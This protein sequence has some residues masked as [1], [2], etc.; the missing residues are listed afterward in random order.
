MLQQPLFLGQG[1]GAGF[2]VMPPIVACGLF[3]VDALANGKCSLCNAD[4]DKWL[5]CSL[6]SGFARLGS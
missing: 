5:A 1:K 2:R 6:E 3:F 4:Y